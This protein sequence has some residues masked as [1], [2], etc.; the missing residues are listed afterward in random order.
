MEAKVPGAIERCTTLITQMEELE[1][2]GLAISKPGESAVSPMRQI[3][4]HL[5][6]KTGR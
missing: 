4:S 5:R 2:F 6:V 1:I 3:H